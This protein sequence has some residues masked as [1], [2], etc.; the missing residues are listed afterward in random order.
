MH[1]YLDDTHVGGGGEANHYHNLCAVLRHIQQNRVC[2]NKEKRM[3]SVPELPC[4][5]IGPTRM[6]PIQWRI[7][8]TALQEAPEPRNKQQLQSFLGPLNFYFLKRAM[9][10]L[11]PLHQRLRNDSV[12]RWSPTETAASERSKK[13]L[14]C[15]DILVNYDLKKP[16]VLAFDALPHDLGFD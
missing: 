5:G 6:A 13:L 2:L 3:F 4:W 7:K 14:T 1:V 10:H 8:V 11:E 12:W 15:S 16:L 9:H